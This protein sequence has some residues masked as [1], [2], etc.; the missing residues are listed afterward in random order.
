[1]NERKNEK[2]RKATCMVDQ[3]M[4]DRDEAPARRPKRDRKPFQEDEADPGE[5]RKLAGIP[6]WKT[7]FRKRKDQGRGTT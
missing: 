6:D 5:A 7:K 3:A 2:L 4:A 1:M